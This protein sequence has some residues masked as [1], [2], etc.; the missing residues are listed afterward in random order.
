[1]IRHIEN[2]SRGQV[3]AGWYR[4]PCAV[5][6][7]A[8]AACAGGNAPSTSAPA[9]DAAKPAESAVGLTPVAAIQDIMDGM[10]MPSADVLWNATSVTSD[11]TGTHDGKPKNDDD[12]KK[13]RYSALTLIEATNLLMMEGRK[14]SKADFPA[15]ANAQ[16]LGSKDIE[17][18]LAK[19]RT[20]FNGFAAAVREL[21]I[22][23]LKTIDERKV[24]PLSDLGGELDEVCESC[25]KVFW[26]PPPAATTAEPAA[27]A[28]PAAP[29]KG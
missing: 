15:D 8:L 20:A 10:V 9:A 2:E 29:A 18:L 4:L 5:L 17:A 13:L 26:Y 11:A 28:T 27:T 16:A 23:M 14:V 19:N 6:L 24:D 1:M 21:G 7:L 25:H 22:S 3:A 12:W